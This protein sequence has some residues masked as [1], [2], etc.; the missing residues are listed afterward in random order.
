MISVSQ[1]DSV[2]IFNPIFILIYNCGNVYFIHALGM[3]LKFFWG[4]YD[5]YPFTMSIL[6]DFLTSQ[7]NSTTTNRKSANTCPLFLYLLSMG[8]SECCLKS[9]NME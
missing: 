8:V 9:V 4:L 5:F 6:I 1:K 7:H 3:R 2:S